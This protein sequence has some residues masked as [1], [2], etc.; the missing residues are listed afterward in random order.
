MDL[1]D[2]E[3]EKLVKEEP[4]SKLPLILGIS[5]S[6]LVIAIIVYF[7]FKNKKQIV[8]KVKSVTKTD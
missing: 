1:F 2:S 8:A 6:L 5:F 4:K 3:E 7:V